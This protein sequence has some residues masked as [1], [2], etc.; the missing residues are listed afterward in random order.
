MPPG[1]L[2]P[3][4]I[5]RLILKT[6][7]KNMIRK[8]GNDIRIFFFGNRKERR[9]EAYRVFRCIWSTLHQCNMEIKY[10]IT[11]VLAL[12][13]MLKLEFAQGQEPIFYMNFDEFGFEER[14][15]SKNEATYM[16]DLQQSQ[17]SEG[18]LGKALDLSANAA[19]R[20]PLKMENGELP[21]FGEK[22]SFTVQIW[23]KT[24]ADAAMGTPIIGNKLAE[25]PTTQGWQLY[26]RENG[27]WALI[28][29]DGKNMYDYVPTAERQRINDGEW[30][31]ILFTVDRNKKETWI[32]FDGINVA[33]YNTPDLKGLQS[34]YTTVI[35]GSDEKWEY[36]S[37][38]Q[39]NAFN[40]F[41]DEIKVWDSVI[42]AETVAKLYSQYRPNSNN[43][44]VASDARHLK[45]LTWNIWHGGHRYGK[46]VGLQRVIE[47][48]KATN[49]DLVGLI[50][51]YGS[52]AIIADSLG[53]YFYL[54]SS[55]LSI[56]S[57]YPIAETIRAF[58]PFNFGGVKLMTGP[59]QDLIFFDTWLHYLPDYSNNI[60]KENK[61]PKALIADEAGTRHAEI[62]EI[63]K[64]ISP[65]LKNTD[66]VPV[67]M[68][69]DFNMGSHLDWTAETKDIH[70][71]KIVEWP[72]SKEMAQAG[73]M[74]SYRELHINPLLD[75]GFT[76][77]PRAATS[78]DKYGLRDR[79]DYIYYKGKG[80][81]PIE[82]KVIDY[83][84]IM[85]PSD[86]AAVLTDFQIK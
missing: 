83:H 60:I 14:H 26:S 65:Y 78:S 73:F 40:G 16:M 43:N 35:G 53:Y 9:L 8:V 13:F 85:F 67:I 71:G 84:P 15:I 7:S 33:I 47:T 56:M 25:D 5:E 28:L 46:E 31:Q 38:G 50:E 86:H 58:K 20:R 49:A 29:N 1:F 63:L 64:E 19:L 11:I 39:W 37:N 54:I 18:L 36:G 23:V 74:D 55:N 3:L 76:W 44:V 48:I 62:K 27:A 17:F 12:I 51:T 68:V 66:E 41:I 69:G 45:V 70:Y 81:N 10:S 21:D 2:H 82:S 77:T 34:Q 75:P 24:L 42:D 22:A 30:H 72:E 79:I 6:K 57:R 52:G 32:Y 61:T 4:A 59:S 80:L